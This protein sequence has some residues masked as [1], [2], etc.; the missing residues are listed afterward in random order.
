MTQPAQ[1]QLVNAHSLNCLSETGLIPERQTKITP[2]TIQC[3]HDY[4]KTNNI[5]CI[6]PVHKELFLTTL[7]LKHQ[8]CLDLN[9]MVY[10][11]FR[12]SKLNTTLS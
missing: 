9:P 12:V 1:S 3:H 5:Y 11:Q 8:V 10:I 2:I 6:I 7:H 4:A